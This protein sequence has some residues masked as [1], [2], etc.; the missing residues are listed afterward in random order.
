MTRVEA[1][2]EA[3]SVYPGEALRFLGRSL[4]GT[5]KFTVEIW[6]MGTT[7]KRMRSGSGRAEPAPL[8]PNWLEDGCGW[9][10]IFLLKVPV[11]WES[12]LYVARFI[13]AGDIEKVTFVVKRKRGNAGALLVVWPVLTF[14]AYNSWGGKSLYS[15]F[16]P[17]VTFDRPGI[18]WDSYGWSSLV[19]WLENY[20]PRADHATSIDVHADPVLLQKYKLL[21]SVWHDEYWTGKMRDHVDEF[22]RAGGNLCVMSGNTCW[23]QARLEA[24]N[25]RLICYR[26]DHQGEYDPAAKKYGDPGAIGPEDVT[27]LWHVNPP[28]R[29]EESTIGVSSR[30]AALANG[31]HTEGFVVRDDQHWAFANTGLVN[32]MPFGVGEPIVGYETDGA[33]LVGEMLVHYWESWGDFQE[34]DG[35][36]DTDDLAL[37]G[38][39]MGHGHDQVLFINRDGSGGRVL[40]ADFTHGPPVRPEYLERWGDFH[41][42]DGWHDADDLA[43]AGDFMG[44]GHDQVLFINRDGGG[45]RVLIA[46]FTHGPPVR[47]EYLELW[48]DFHELDGWHDAGDLALAGDFMGR[49]HDQV[50][51]INRDGG[52][53]RVLIADFTHGPPVRPEYLELWGQ[54]MWLDQWD[55][56]EQHRLVGDFLAYGRDQLFVI[57][58]STSPGTAVMVDFTSNPAQNF[59]QSFSLGGPDVV[60]GGMY[61]RRDWIVPGRFRGKTYDRDGVGVAYNDI[62][63]IDRPVPNARPGTGRVLA[64]A[65]LDATLQSEYHELWGDSPLLDGWTDDE[66]L[67][68]TGDFMGRGFD[69]ALFINRTGGGG[70]V[71]IA[72]AHRAIT[73][74]PKLRGA[75]AGFR[76]LATADLFNP[77]FSSYLRLAPIGTAVLGEFQ[78]NPAFAGL[79]KSIVLSFGTTGWTRGLRE[80]SAWNAVS[81]ITVNVL[82]E[83]SK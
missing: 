50:L 28:G 59:P 63:F 26:V 36:H 57:D 11:S 8:P 44:R 80:R 15:A 66:D 64:A 55:L 42:L 39:F 3:T 2:S 18:D 52:G 78:M 68:L 13:V 32:G 35:W 12:G 34:L 71:L 4:Q 83:L 10:E 40:I 21:L 82:D 76:V 79:V 54:S 67:L 61:D 41:E 27:G 29:P 16:T 58:C 7:P 60:L 49:G 30:F 5:T 6:R 81:Q 38:D 77:D 56:P 23:W 22:V 46:D 45:G 69:Q 33:D 9:P 19:A 14:Q 1:Y 75:A 17:V 73:S 31:S 37:A 74:P 24:N 53:G 65:F 20:G 47:P 25:R 70:R 48:G 72:S 43:L 51:F 62:L